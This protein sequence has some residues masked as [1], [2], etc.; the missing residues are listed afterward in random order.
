ML[1]LPGQWLLESIVGP[2][3]DERDENGNE[4]TKETFFQKYIPDKFINSRS[5]LLGGIK[6][7]LT[8]PPDHSSSDNLLEGCGISSLFSE[9]PI[10]AIQRIHFAKP[11]ITLE[12]FLGALNPKFGE[13]GMLCTLSLLI[14]KIDRA[15]SNSLFLR[16]IMNTFYVEPDI[17]WGMS[18]KDK[19]RQEEKQKSFYKGGFMK[20]L[21]ESADEDESFL[22]KFVECATGSN[23]L[24]FDKNFKINIEFNFSLDVT[25][26]KFH[27]CTRDVML[28]G[29]EAFFAD[30]ESFKNDKMNFAI[31]EV[32]NQFNME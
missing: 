12:D 32:Y 29:V 8:L 27:S 2:D 10:E 9:F 18:K 7:G 31:N 24:P 19:E 26:P 13:G 23:Y 3:C 16:I 25:L 21:K 11:Y 15:L 4:W 20:Y 17:A 28:P 6:D 14:E 22:V 1:D 5:I 30:Y